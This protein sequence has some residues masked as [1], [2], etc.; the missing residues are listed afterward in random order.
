MAIFLIGTAKEDNEIGATTWILRYI[1]LNPALAN[2]SQRVCL[3]YFFSSRIVF[4][5][6][7]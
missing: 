3:N 2:Q 1:F 5:A 7:Q 6:N 4:D